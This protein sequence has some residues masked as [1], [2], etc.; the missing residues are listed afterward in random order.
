MG[1]H[2]E[3]FQT[4]VA[5]TTWCGHIVLRFMQI[6]LRAVTLSHLTSLKGFLYWNRESYRSSHCISAY[7]AKYNW[8]VFFKNFGQIYWSV[9][10]WRV[11]VPVD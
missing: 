4:T 8:S 1:Q 5:A 9:I 3:I 2:Y 11:L 6:T 7:V 10:T